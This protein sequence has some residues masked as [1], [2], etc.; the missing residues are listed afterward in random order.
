[1]NLDPQLM[2][3]GE[4]NRF[5]KAV[6]FV[7][8]HEGGYSNDPDDPGGETNF[9]I[10]KK[11]HPD[12]DIKNLTPEKAADIYYNEYWVPSKACERDFPACV[13]V[14]DTAV[15]CGVSRAL[16]F[17]GDPFDVDSLLTN[18][19]MFYIQKV[20]E[21]PKKQKFLGGWMARVGDVKKLLETCSPSTP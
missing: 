16:T 20:K 18:R 19:T 12:V 21:T 14:L 6:E 4:Y 3:S 7:L 17:G 13:A 8:K 2:R 10:A 9:G 11:Y 1:M 15:N 5:Y